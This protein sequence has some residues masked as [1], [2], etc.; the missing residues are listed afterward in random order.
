MFGEILKR[1]SEN[2]AIT[3]FAENLRALLTQPPLVGQVVLGLDPGFRTGCKVAVVDPTGMLLETANIYP[4]GPQNEWV[5]AL[6]ILERLA[7]RHLVTLI[8]IGNGTAS[9]ETEQLVAELIRSLPK[10]HYLMVN[11]AGASVYSASSLARSELPDLDVSIRGAVS[12]AR[13]VQDPLAELVK[14]DPKSIGV[15]LYQH[16]VDQTQLTNALDSVVENVVNSVGVDLNTAS[17]A[18]LTYV[19]GVGPKL[20]EKII[21]HRN[22]IGPFPD[23]S[24]LTNVSGMGPKAFEQAAGFLRVRGGSNPLDASAIHPES[25]AAAETILSKAGLSMSSILNGKERITS[26]YA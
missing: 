6:E 19:A 20:A 9:R 14:I 4:H 2:H 16:D 15:G 7:R 21:A 5:K 1:K 18:L 24:S 3:V 26:Y 10:I 17:A 11:E 8:A 12:I 23:R 25:Y 13:R 22:K